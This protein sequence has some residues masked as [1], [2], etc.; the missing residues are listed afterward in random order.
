[1]SNWLSNK[2]SSYN[3]KDLYQENYGGEEK[4]YIKMEGQNSRGTPVTLED[5]YEII[6]FPSIQEAA[7]HCGCVPSTLMYH[8]ENG[9]PFGGY[10]IRRKHE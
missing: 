6:E 2:I 4:R 10:K 9:T 8:E 1:M 3:W 7:D 5:D